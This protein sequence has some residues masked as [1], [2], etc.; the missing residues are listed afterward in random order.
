M[1]AQE[2]VNLLEQYRTDWDKDMADAELH[3]H[4]A[5]EEWVGRLT[6]E[7]FVGHLVHQQGGHIMGFYGGQDYDGCTLLG[8]RGS[9]ENSPALALAANEWNEPFPDPG[10]I[11]D[12]A[13]K[14]GLSEEIHYHPITQESEKEAWERLH[15]AVFDSRP[16]AGEWIFSEIKVEDRPVDF[17]LFLVKKDRTGDPIR[18]GSCNKHRSKSGKYAQWE[19]N[20]FVYRDFQGTEPDP[21]QWDAVWVD[22]TENKD[23]VEVGIPFYYTNG[24]I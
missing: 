1:D 19:S 17:D 6:G 8:I 14:Q 24:G 11:V 10:W 12:V 2:F 5:G 9:H 22:F 23:G 16:F 15:H 3:I 4:E 18:I 21:T 13:W 20:A 7:M